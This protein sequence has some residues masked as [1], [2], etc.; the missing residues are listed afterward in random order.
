MKINNQYTGQVFFEHLEVGDVFIYSQEQGVYIKIVDV[1]DSDDD[2]NN[3][4]NLKNGVLCAVSDD[5]L[6]L[7]VS[8][9][10]TIS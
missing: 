2:Y 7:R 6:V 10:L 5:D 1:T 3:A 9:E 8:A 4:V